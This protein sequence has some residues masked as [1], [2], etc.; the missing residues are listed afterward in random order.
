MKWSG[1]NSYHNVW[2]IYLFV[3][4]MHPFLFKA[5][6]SE[7]ESRISTLLKWKCNSTFL[8]F[9]FFN[10]CNCIRL[11]LYFQ[12]L[13]F[14]INNLLGPQNITYAL[15]LPKDL[16]KVLYPGKWCQSLFSVVFVKCSMYN[17]LSV[18][19]CFLPLQM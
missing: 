1:S 10:L 17:W 14:R 13:N 16:C 12:I 15:H 9:S 6:I 18:T 19:C 8:I 4:L 2:N 5:S 11:C 7:C 3:C